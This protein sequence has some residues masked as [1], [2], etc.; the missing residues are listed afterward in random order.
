M[1]A[2]FGEEETR[3]CVDGERLI[4]KP[5]GAPLAQ[6]ES[7]TGFLLDGVAYPLL[8]DNVSR[9]LPNRLRRL[10]Q[11]VMSPPH[12]FSYQSASHELTF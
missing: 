1:P 5:T 4:V 6:N 11:P 2:C 9:P 12:G 8:A 10:I 3:G 7:N